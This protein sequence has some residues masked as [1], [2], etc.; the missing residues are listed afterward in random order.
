MVTHEE[1]IRLLIKIAC[2]EAL[3]RDLERILDAAPQRI[4]AIDREIETLEKKLHQGQ[5]SIDKWKREKIRLD[6]EIRA[7]T[8]AI[9]KKQAEQINAKTNE[10]YRAR[11]LEIE[12]L[13]KK[14]DGAEERI[15]EILDR[16]DEAGREVDAVTRKINTEKEAMLLQRQE[17]VDAI[18]RAGSELAA[19]KQEKEQVLAQLSGRTRGFYRRILAVKKNTAVA[20]LIDDICQGCHS[21]VP[22]Q[23]SHEVRRN[24]TMITCE[25][26]GRILVYFDSE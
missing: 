7:E 24:D 26:C 18:E 2:K 3:I 14:I 22:P 9:E 21:R 4:A 12:F 20:N 25:A 5:E 16:M 13:K 15:L 10:E 23:K 8:S 6:D 17:H 19:L 1:D 11:N